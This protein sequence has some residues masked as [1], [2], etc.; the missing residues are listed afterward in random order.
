MRRR[1]ALSEHHRSAAARVIPFPSEDDDCW[2]QEI[3]SEWSVQ[4]AALHVYIESG[5]L[6]IEALLQAQ[7]EGFETFEV[8]WHGLPPWRQ[9]VLARQLAPRWEELLGVDGG[10]PK[11]GGGDVGEETESE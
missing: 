6:G 9:E 4:A 5:Q 1:A 7:R 2:P 8:F 11:E 10:D 3:L